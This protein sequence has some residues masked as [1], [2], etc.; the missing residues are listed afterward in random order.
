M[1]LVRRAGQLVVLGIE[2]SC[3]DTAVS[4]IDGSKKVLSQVVISQH[5][6]HARHKGIV[7]YL[8]TQAHR[9]MLPVA[10]KQSLQEAGLCLEKI[11]VF[12]VTRG[13]GIV[14]SLRV[15]WEFANTLSK[16]MDRP[17]YNVNHLVKIFIS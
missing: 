14:G 6:I 5:P 2:T 7:P 3:D 17:C 8:A 16:L 11:D 15:G 1:S 13:P 12:A 4:I 10:V 9:K